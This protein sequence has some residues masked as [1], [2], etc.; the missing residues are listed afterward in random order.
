MLRFC[1]FSVDEESDEGEDVIEDD[2]DSEDET[3]PDQ[4]GLLTT[5]PPGTPAAPGFQHRVEAPPAEPHRG[6]SAAVAATRGLHIAT[7]GRHQR[8]ASG[9]GPGPGLPQSPRPP[10]RLPGS[11]A[12]SSISPATPR[13]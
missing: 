4:S 5:S 3:D 9:L 11:P 10:G 2:S 6:H 12:A 1:C 8:S 7:S 13:I